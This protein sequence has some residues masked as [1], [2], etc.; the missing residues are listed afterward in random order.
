[1]SSYK[2]KE[3]NYETNNKNQKIIICELNNKNKDKIIFDYDSKYDPPDYN[4][5]KVRDLYY[6][7][8]KYDSYN[9]THYSNKFK[10]GKKNWILFNPTIINKN[11]Y[12]E[13][14]MN[15]YFKDTKPKHRLFMDLTYSCGFIRYIEQRTGEIVNYITNFFNN[16]NSNSYI[17]KIFYNPRYKIGG[18]TYLSKKS[19]DDFF[20]PVFD[21]HIRGKQDTTNAFFL[22][23]I[24]LKN[25][26]DFMYLTGGL[27]YFHAKSLSYYSEQ[28]HYTY[29]FFQIYYILTNQNKNGSFI[30]QLNSIIDSYLGRTLLRFLKKYYTN[31]YLV[32]DVDFSSDCL[33]IV[34][35][36]FTGI[37]KSD[38]IIVKKLFKTIFYNKRESSNKFVFIFGEEL[39]VFDD[40]LRRKKNVVRLFTNFVKNI[41]LSRLIKFNNNDLIFDKIIDKFNNRICNYIMEK[42]S[43]K[44]NT[45][46]K[47][48]MKNLP[49]K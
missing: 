37:N 33:Y 6:K 43:D 5:K 8:S 17:N 34:G 19:E 35:K 26:Q 30:I 44:Y 45:P 9:L 12:L 21:T 24:S 41:Y 3:I 32:R 31:L 10:V 25:K 40:E 42:Y 13:F 22:K 36:N 11:I 38:L 18:D 28:I 16:N 4:L 2:I 27:E 46:K 20:N 14:I 23:D 29:F 47:F 48:T 15:T 49:N 7:I 39:N 1:M